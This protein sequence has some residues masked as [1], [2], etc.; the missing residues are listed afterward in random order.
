MA[1]QARLETIFGEERELYVRINNVEASN[2][3][4]LATALARGYLNE[5]AFLE[6]KAFVWERPFAFAA[7][8]SEPLWLQAY[9]AL[10]ESPDFIEAKDA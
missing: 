10:R 2:H 8:V 9:A 6:R 7:N 3:G 4:N 1:L 5:Q